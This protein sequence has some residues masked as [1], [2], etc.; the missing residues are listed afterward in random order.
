[1]EDRSL[2]AGRGYEANDGI[3]QHH[4]KRCESHIDERFVG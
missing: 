1:M 3:D 2:W 4:G